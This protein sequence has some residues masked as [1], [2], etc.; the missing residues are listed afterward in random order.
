[1]SGGTF[2]GGSGGTI[3]AQELAT[4]DGGNGFYANLHNFVINGGQ[5]EGGNGGAITA[6]GFTQEPSAK[7]GYGFYSYLNHYLE[8]NGGTFTGGEGGIINNLQQKNAAGLGIVDTP[9]LIKGGIFSDNAIFFESQIRNNT[10]N[11]ESVTLGEVELSSYAGMASSAIFEDVDLSALL[12]SESGDKLLD[13]TN[14]QVGNII[15][16][17]GNVEL[18]TFEN[19]SFEAIEIQNGSF[20]Y[21]TGRFHALQWRRD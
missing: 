1:M 12:L 20:D 7:G 16:E 11:I 14:V 18:N 8:I 15:V 17:S 2:S 3:V 6:S 13:L 19:S 4:A 9:A 10:L 21:N 5:F